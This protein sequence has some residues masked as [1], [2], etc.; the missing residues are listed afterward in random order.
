[1]GQTRIH[2]DS[3]LDGTEDTHTQ[4]LAEAAW[5][6]SRDER[7]ARGHAGGYCLT[8]SAPYGAKDPLA[9]SVHPS[10][11]ASGC[12][13]LLHELLARVLTKLRISSV[14]IND[15]GAYAYRVA[16]TE[17]ID[18]KRSER[19][20]LGFPARPTRLDGAAG[21]VDGALRTVGG[22]R[23][24]WF[25]ALFRILRS[26]P[27]TNT[28]VPG[29]WPVEG[30]AVERAHYFP[31]DCDQIERVRHD[32]ATVIGR[33]TA[34][35]GHAWVYHNL[36]LPL[37]AGTAPALLPEAHPAHPVDT[38]H[39]LLSRMLWQEYAR[40]RASGHPPQDAL[41]RAARAVT[42]RGAPSLTREVERALAELED[43]TRREYAIA[44]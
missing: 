11:R 10:C 25:S 42:G 9:A 23:A 4:K 5:L 43:A 40:Q 31:D 27:F 17:L 16:C 41:E 32:I 28:H 3:V 44:S 24:E 20:A 12:F 35:A 15:L 30:L 37:N 38:V 2:P 13:D 34:V 33:A 19:A 21:R 8:R 1:M 26:Y 39:T 36:T 6:A 22:A 29:R 14:A 7:N 18:L